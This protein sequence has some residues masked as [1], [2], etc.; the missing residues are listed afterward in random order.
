MANHDDERR[1][2]AEERMRDLLDTAGLPPPDAVVHHPGEIL[3]LWSS[4]KTAIVLEL[5]GEAA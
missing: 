5:D 1:E 3:F 2:V 4:S